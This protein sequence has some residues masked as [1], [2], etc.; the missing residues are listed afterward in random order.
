MQAVKNQVKEKGMIFTR[1]SV[2]AILENRKSQTRRVIK[3]VGI[4]PGIGPIFKGSDDIKEWINMSPYPVGTRIWVRETLGIVIDYEDHSELGGNPRE[5]FEQDLLYK[6]DCVDMK[7]WNCPK[8]ISSRYM[9]RIYSRINLL[10]TKVRAEKI[11]DITEE[12]AK[13][14]GIINEGPK[15][16]WTCDNFTTPTDDGS[17]YSTG[18]EAFRE[19]WDSINGKK[20][21]CP[22]EDNPFCW[23]Y[24]FEVEK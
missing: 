6:A 19:L 22:W 24:D 23:V 14:E 2:R 15:Y 20:K 1:E 17:W 21:G 9:P 11:Q 18:K 12:D 13:A 5:Y 3:D 8:W 16:N 4:A 10:V 7:P